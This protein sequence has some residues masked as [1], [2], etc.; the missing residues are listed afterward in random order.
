M[1]LIIIASKMGCLSN[2][3]GEFPVGSFGS[4]GKIKLYIFTKNDFG[5]DE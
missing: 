2:Q 1:S 4:F 3:K 5:C